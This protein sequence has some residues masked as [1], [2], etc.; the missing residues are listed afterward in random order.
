MKTLDGNVYNRELITLDR[1]K[2]NYLIFEGACE[3]EKS[4][5]V[6]QNTP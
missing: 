1:P 5:M 3:K 2:G 4:I 6:M